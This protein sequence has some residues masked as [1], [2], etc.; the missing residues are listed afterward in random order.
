MYRNNEWNNR[1]NFKWKMH[2]SRNA[3]FIFHPDLPRR[4]EH[5][6]LNYFRLWRPSN[7]EEF[8]VVSG[9]DVS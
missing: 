8:I 5:D 7:L 1:K 3:I 6:H 9:S 4:V 2:K